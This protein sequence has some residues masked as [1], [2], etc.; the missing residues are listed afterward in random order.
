M[1]TETANDRD[2]PDCSARRRPA[3]RRR[4][5]RHA[6]RRDCRRPGELDD[7]R[8]SNPAAEGLS[9]RR[10]HGGFQRRACRALPE[11][12]PSRETVPQVGGLS[13][14]PV[15][16]PRRREMILAALAVSTALAVAT[17]TVTP[18]PRI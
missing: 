14:R 13:G 12:R 3:F 7:P 5:A 17:P 8:L 9:W 4:R 15:L 2:A 18:P 1:R 10:T 6:R 11:G 16:S